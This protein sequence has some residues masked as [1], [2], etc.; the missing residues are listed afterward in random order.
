MAVIKTSFI[1]SLLYNAAG[2]GLA[3]QGLLTPLTAAVLMPVS[4]I[5]IVSFGVLATN[6]FAKKRRLL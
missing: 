3:L 5:T 6:F 4:S 2:L 1:L